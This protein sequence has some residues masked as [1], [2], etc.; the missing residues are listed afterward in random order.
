MFSRLPTASA[1]AVA[2]AYST[3]TQGAAFA[4]AVGKRLNESMFDIK[5]IV[6]HR[7][8]R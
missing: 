2:R 4:L 8:L 6:A 7:W 3:P 5:T 1:C